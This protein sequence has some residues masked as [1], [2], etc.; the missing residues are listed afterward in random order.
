MKKTVYSYCLQN[1]SKPSAN[2]QTRAPEK[3]YGRQDQISS[4]VISSL[5]YQNC[6]HHIAHR[7]TF[8]FLLSHSY[9]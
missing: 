1:S 2:C 4:K 6:L 5:C 3:W 9:R 8:S 7:R